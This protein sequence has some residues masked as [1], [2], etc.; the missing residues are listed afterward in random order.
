MLTIQYYLL[1]N[2]RINQ[3]SPPQYFDKSMFELKCLEEILQHFSYFLQ[4]KTS[5][6]RNREVITIEA[7]HW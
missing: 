3:F 7:F 1:E 6:S 2:Q 4:N 5:N